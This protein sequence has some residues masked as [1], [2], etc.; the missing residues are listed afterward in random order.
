MKSFE[1]MKITKKLLITSFI[2]LIPIILL[3]GAFILNAYQSINVTK[4][5]LKGIQYI[6]TLSEL[7]INALDYDSNYRIFSITKDEQIKKDIDSL[8]NSINK[9]FV[10]IREIDKKYS[11]F[12]AYNMINNLEKEWKG[13]ENTKVELVDFKGMDFVTNIKKDI[14]YI[15][16]K[17]GLILDTEL[18]TYYLISTIIRQLPRINDCLYELLETDKIVVAKNE[19]DA[20]SKI[21]FNK[22]KNNLDF[23]YSK[24]NDYLNYSFEYNKNIKNQLFVLFEKLQKSKNLFL[25]SLNKKDDI[26]LENFT[27]ENSQE[28]QKLGK[29][30]L[31]LNIQFTKTTLQELN[32]LFK[33]RINKQIGSIFLWVFIILLILA[34][35][36][37]FILSIIMGITNSIE[38]LDIASKL[39]ANGHIDT[40]VQIERNDEI[41]SLAKTFNFMIDN[42]K[43]LMN[44]LKDEKKQLEEK[45]KIL[46]EKIQE[47]LI[48]A[49]EIKIEKESV[50]NKISEAVQNTEEQK[51]YLADRAEKLLLAM[52]KFSE[53]DLRVKLIA[54]N[55]D[56]ELIKRIYGGFNKTVSNISKIT[57]QIITAIETIAESVNQ[58]KE[59]SETIS[60]ATQEQS[61]QSGQVAASIEEMT[62]TVY[63]SADSAKMTSDA[64]IN[65]GKV[66][67]EGGIVVNSTI[68]KIRE[69]ARVVEE[70]ANMIQKLGESSV[71][72]DEIVAVID[73]I[74]TQT[75][76]L[77][78][79]A[80]IEAARAGEQ[81][82]G[83]AVVADEV[84]K[85][86]EKTT[87]ATK[88]IASMIRNIQNE[89]QRAVISIQD[90][91]KQVSEGLEYS[92]KTGNALEKIVQET[93]TVVDMIARIA[94]GTAQQSQ[95]TES[96]AENIF[97]I[98]L[99]SQ[100]TANDIAKV[101]DSTDDLSSLTEN[102]QELMLQF[103]ID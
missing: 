45:E 16:N 96:I 56:T 52:D 75:N 76:L 62:R 103:K 66:A 71:A 85:L 65:N 48:L 61:S 95:V 22:N 18:D 10:K 63:E 70:S 24:L 99:V 39:I 94:A 77:A 15:G 91:T 43:A 27:L 88:E 69:I 67:K 36:M 101:A 20:D 28:F 84:R 58:I 81:G 25:E 21:T 44:N 11:S 3:L 40:Y 60:S 7:E 26:A 83:F 4:N 2:A 33:T 89:T 68:Q 6:E 31:D 12:N 5:Q 93:N 80:A 97:S 42:I 8:T 30:F 34:I 37:F 13:L 82:R 19:L 32:K 38:K 74:A 64:A 46:Q 78:L 54:S 53:G 79:N 23:E 100:Q 87:T 90:G 17:S 57:K 73:E 55:N 98:S 102:L 86:A 49:K 14:E 9:N 29:D 35:A 50:E 41:G 1:N 59:F 92:E 72:I 47:S 51:E